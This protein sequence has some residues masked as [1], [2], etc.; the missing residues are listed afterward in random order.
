MKRTTTYIILAIFFIVLGVYFY[1]K[2]TEDDSQKEYRNK[3]ILLPLS[4]VSVVNAIDI[5]QKGL[6]TTF[7]KDAGRWKTL[8][9]YNVYVSHAENLI[10]SASTAVIQSA[11]SSSLENLEKFN[12]TDEKAHHYVLRDG[13]KI[14]GGF[15]IAMGDFGNGYVVRDKEEAVMNIDEPDEIF[16]LYEWRDS[17]LE[18]IRKRDI[19]EVSIKRGN[20]IIALLKD[21]ENEWRIDGQMA[22]KEKVDEYLNFVAAATASGFPRAD[23]DFKASETSLKIKTKDAAFLLIL[24]QDIGENSLIKNSRGL[25]Y[26]IHKNTKSKLFP[27]KKDLL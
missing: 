8:E 15:K 17:A 11:V 14:L 24:G 19:K 13:D 6:K 16:F 23:D 9:G 3:K 26:L 18:E 20:D 1:Q 21:P 27:K 2:K 7:I 22:D 25:L 10:K 12:L 5:E 4:S